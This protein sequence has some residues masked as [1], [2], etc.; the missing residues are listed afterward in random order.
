MYYLPN[1]LLRLVSIYMTF[2]LLS[3]LNNNQ[4]YECA[5]GLTFLDIVNNNIQ[6]WKLK[7]CNKT[8]IV[9]NDHPSEKLCYR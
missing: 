7:N 2:K 1:R 9:N 5:P 3:T 4:E 6:L 8:I